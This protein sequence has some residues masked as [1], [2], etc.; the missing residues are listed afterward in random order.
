MES[1]ELRILFQADGS[2]LF[3]SATIPRSAIMRHLRRAGA[4]LAENPSE[5]R[6]RPM[7]AFEAE[8]RRLLGRDG[9]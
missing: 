4:W 9:R 1:H 8:L 6:D 7:G 3:T 5:T 2:V